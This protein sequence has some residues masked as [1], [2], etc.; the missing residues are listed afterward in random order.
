MPQGQGSR[1]RAGRRGRQ[2][3]GGR[4]LL[5]PSL[6]LLLAEDDSHGYQIYDRLEELG[7]DPECLDPSVVYRDL[8]EMEAAGLIASTWDADSKGPKKRVYRILDRGR[9]QLSEWIAHLEEHQRR[10]QILID[11]LQ[12]SIA[13]N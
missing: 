8:R 5:Q 3:K 6:L 7:F 2:G 10:V 13:R 11:R 12:K 1:A 9:S 4:M